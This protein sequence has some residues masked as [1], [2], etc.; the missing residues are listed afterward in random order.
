M[1]V[2]KLRPEHVGPLENLNLK[3]TAGRSSSPLL[4]AEF[5]PKRALSASPSADHLLHA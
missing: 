4:V 5:P 2:W 3:P 1:F